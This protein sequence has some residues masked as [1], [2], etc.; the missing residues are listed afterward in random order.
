MSEFNNM[1]ASRGQGNAGVALGVVGT[2]LGALNSIGGGLWNNGNWNRAGCGNCGG[3]CSENTP[4][5][6]YDMQMQQELAAK[7][8]KIAL[9]EANTYNDQKSLELYKYVDG[10][11]R[12]FEAALASQAV[13]NQKTADDIKLVRKD[14]EIEAERRCCADNAIVNYANATF[15]A[16]LIAGV[17]PTTTDPTPQST[18][19]PIPNCKPCCNN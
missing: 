3:E 17:T 6:R 4:V 15:Y 13:V 8:S 14:V 19:N 10:R 16:K 11:F 5:T 18:Y 9:L 1:Y 7:D 2:A 12:E